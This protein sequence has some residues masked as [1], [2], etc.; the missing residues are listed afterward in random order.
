MIDQYISL[1]IKDNLSFIGGSKK[2]HPFYIHVPDQKRPADFSLESKNV[3]FLI[4]VWISNH[5]APFIRY[6]VVYHYTHYLVYI[7]KLEHVQNNFILYIL[8]LSYM[9][10]TTMLCGCSTCESPL[11][12]TTGSRKILH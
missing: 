6:K 9:T 2:D 3:N 7:R 4:S 11:L 12:R 8:H 1:S 5:H 10:I